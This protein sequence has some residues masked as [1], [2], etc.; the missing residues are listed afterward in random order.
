MLQRFDE[1]PHTSTREV[2]ANVGC[3]HMTVARIAKEQL[4]HPFKLVQVQAL[5][6]QDFPTRLQ[7]CQ[8][9]QARVAEVPDFL[10][11]ILSSDEKGFPREDTFNA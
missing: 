4:L 8:W 9:L 6:P 3:S 10:G 11:L 7:Y 1:N 5:G 2:A